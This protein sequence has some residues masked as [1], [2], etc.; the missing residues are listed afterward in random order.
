MTE[1]TLARCIGSMSA[2]SGGLVVARELLVQR[3]SG[4]GTKL[5]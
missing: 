3:Q 2:L 1:F 4:L 5:A